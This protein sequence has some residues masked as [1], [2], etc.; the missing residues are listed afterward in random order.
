M[1]NRRY[2]TGSRFR[3]FTLVELLV[4]IGII[5]VLIGILLPSLNMARRQALRVNCASNLRQ[6]GMA[7][8]MYAIGNQGW[9][10]PMYDNPTANPPDFRPIFTP[11]CYVGNHDGVS[12]LV[13]PPDGVA[14]QKYL[15]NPDVLFCPADQFMPD[16]RVRDIHGN[17]GFA[18]N[19]YMSYWYYFC[20]STGLQQGGVNPSYIQLSRYRYGQ[21]NPTG[22]P[23]M[24]IMSDS[25]SVYPAIERNPT[26]YGL[27]NTFCHFRQPKGWNVLYTDGHVIFVRR[28]DVVKR[29]NFSNDYWVE[30]LGI[31]DRM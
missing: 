16:L 28:D 27:G 31:L 4:V 30:F 21:K 6:I 5:V 1:V 13:P 9:L 23:G 11:G 25:G 7:F 18:N 2:E 15:P 26:R 17:L 8:E 10:P 12:L 22:A 24:A 3:G 19:E 14:A 29:M 20:P